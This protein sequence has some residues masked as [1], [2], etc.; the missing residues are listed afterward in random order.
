MNCLAKRRHLKTLNLQF[1]FGLRRT[2]LAAP[3]SLIIFLAVKKNILILLPFVG[4]NMRG[5]DPIDFGA[6]K[7]RSQ[8]PIDSSTCVVTFS[9]LLKSKWWN[10][11][12]W[13]EREKIVGGEILGWVLNQHPLLYN[14]EIAN[15]VLN[16]L[17]ARLKRHNLLKV[18]KMEC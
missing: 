5:V 11:Y 15:W 13:W 14:L 7:K 12:H 10:A 17:V 9:S 8:K 4:L 18:A 3:S 6:F 2:V 16:T 1:R